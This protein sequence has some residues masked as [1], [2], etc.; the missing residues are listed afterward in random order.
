MHLSEFM[1]L[2]TFVS[3]V[4]GSLISWFF[5]RRY[6]VKAGQELQAEAAE[7][8]HLNNLLLRGLENAGMM[9][10]ARDEH[11]NPTGLEIALEAHVKSSSSAKATLS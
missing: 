10:V 11:G 8:R 9:K 4:I 7:L 2:K 6:Y 1:D 3:I 5:S